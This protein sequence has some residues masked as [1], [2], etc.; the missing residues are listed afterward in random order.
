MVTSIFSHSLALFFWFSLLSS[1]LNQSQYLFWPLA[2][3][4]FLD[5]LIRNSSPESAHDKVG[6]GVGARVGAGAGAG[7]GSGVG[8]R[9]GAGVGTFVGDGVG[10]GVGSGIGDGTGVGSGVGAGVGSGVG[11]WVGAWVGA[12]VGS[13][14]GPNVDVGAG[15][16]PGVVTGNPRVRAASQLKLFS[17]PQGEEGSRNFWNHSSLSIKLCGASRM[18]NDT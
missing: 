12:G 3:L 1:L 9:V 14:D 4:N 17:S 7:V 11:T 10:F 2:S 18:M 15:V 6:A 5:F 16:G 13:S 8:S